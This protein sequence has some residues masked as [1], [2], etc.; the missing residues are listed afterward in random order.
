ML[1]C[2]QYDFNQRQPL[3]SYPM[4]KP[5]ILN[6]KEFMV[7][8]RKVTV[9]RQDVAGDEKPHQVVIRAQVKGVTKKETWSYPAGMAN[10][11]CD[12]A[13]FDQARAEKFVG[14]LLKFLTTKKGAALVAAD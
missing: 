13:E 11:D 5:K 6:K 8:R 2:S 14:G 1:A 9:R 10:C 12:F 4:A 7:G 3:N